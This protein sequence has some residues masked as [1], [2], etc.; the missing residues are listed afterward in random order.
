MKKLLL[1]I[2]LVAASIGVFAQSAKLGLK[3]GLNFA[4]L[5]AS[6]GGISGSTQSLTSFSAGA[7][8]DLKLGAL[9]V[10]P[11]L[12]YT[13][14]GGTDG[15]GNKINLYYVQVPVNLVYHVPVVVGNIYFGG[16]PYVA[17]GISGTGKDASGTSTDVTFGDGEDNIKRNDFGLNGIAG[18]QFT[19]GFLVG[20]NYDLGLSNILNTNEVSTRNRV[21]GVSVGFTF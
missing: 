21:F 3:G 19:S 13:G 6:Y 16:G 2:A 17:Y 9:S 11:A 18:F 5:N 1:S 12:L 8:I 15:D 7:F 4:K 10:Q 20:I 14:K